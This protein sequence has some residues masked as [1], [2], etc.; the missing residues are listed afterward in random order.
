[1]VSQ[2]I[3]FTGVDA[4]WFQAVLGAM[5]L[6]AVLVNQVCIRAAQGALDRHAR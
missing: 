2:G 5:L 6:G 3:F 1:M 4:D